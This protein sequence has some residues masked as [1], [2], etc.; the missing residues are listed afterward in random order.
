MENTFINNNIEYKIKYY[1]D[2]CNQDLL[3]QTKPTKA[4]PEN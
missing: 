1:E 4:R 3:G 2:I